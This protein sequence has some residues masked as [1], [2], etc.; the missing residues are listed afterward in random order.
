MVQPAEEAEK[1]SSFNYGK[2]DTK[3]G[4]HWPCYVEHS[5]ISVNIDDVI[6]RF[7]D[8]KPRRIAL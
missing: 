4:S 8:E 2:L 1:L 7:H 3:R 5:S 6:N